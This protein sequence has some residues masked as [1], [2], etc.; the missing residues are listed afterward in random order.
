[1]AEAAPVRCEITSGSC[2]AEA[3]NTVEKRLLLDQTRPH[4]E[5][6]ASAKAFGIESGQE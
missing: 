5:L 3:T 1:V 2:S 4:R 6:A